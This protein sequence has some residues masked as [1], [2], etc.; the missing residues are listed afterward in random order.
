MTEQEPGTESGIKPKP[1]T[2]THHDQKVRKKS[3]SD[4]MMG[5]RQ[6]N[7][8]HIKISSKRRKRISKSTSRDPKFNKLQLL[9]LQLKLIYK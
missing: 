5:L 7:E 1:E 3:R 4:P 2:P 6:V 8:T 9:Q